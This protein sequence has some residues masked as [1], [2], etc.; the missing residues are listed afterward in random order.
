MTAIPVIKWE[1]ALLV[2]KATSEF[3]TIELLGVFPWID[4]LIII[5]KQKRL[6]FSANL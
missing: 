6:N 3:S 2:I 4:I 5:L 1:N